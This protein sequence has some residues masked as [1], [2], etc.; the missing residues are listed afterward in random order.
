LRLGV[1]SKVHTYIGFGSAGC[2]E[3]WLCLAGR[4]PIISWA[5]P[6][7]VFSIQEVEAAQPKMKSKLNY[8]KAEPCLT[9]AGRAESNVSV[10]FSGKACELYRSCKS[11]KSYILPQDLHFPPGIIQSHSN[12]LLQ[13][14]IVRNTAV[15]S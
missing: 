13:E 2:C 14:L 10:N 9:T 3:A 6:F 8:G 12:N 15:F 4:D 7:F 1:A 11:Y 5:A